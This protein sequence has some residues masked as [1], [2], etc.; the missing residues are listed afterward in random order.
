MDHERRLFMQALRAWASTELGVD[1][2]FVRGSSYWSTD[3]CSGRR[4][5]DSIYTQVFVGKQPLRADGRQVYM[6]GVGRLRV[7]GKWDETWLHIGDTKRDTKHS[8]TVHDLLNTHD[9]HEVCLHDRLAL[10]R[11]LIDNEFMPAIKAWLREVVA[12]LKARSNAA[13]KDLRE[14]Y[15]AS[16]RP[17]AAEAAAKKGAPSQKSQK[18][19]RIAIV[20][21]ALQ[22]SPE[23]MAAFI[24]L[25]Q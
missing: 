5:I 8:S 12:N 17:A 6:N 22:H 10:V 24:Q 2:D 7:G 15:T 16:K 25:S 23:A 20:T 1:L 14:K 21:K 13:L 11:E 4:C 18:D 9:E 19:K 3:L